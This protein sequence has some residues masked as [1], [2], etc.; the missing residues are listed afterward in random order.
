MKVA[1]SSSFAW[2]KLR[3][4]AFQYEFVEL[5]LETE[6]YWHESD[7]HLLLSPYSNEN[8]EIQTISINITNTCVEKLKRSF[9]ELENWKKWWE[10]ALF[11]H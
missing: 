9:E 1:L 8:C 10:N 3:K 11:F 5:W 4:Y 6:I 7:I 2:N